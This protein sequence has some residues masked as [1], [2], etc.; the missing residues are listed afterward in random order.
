MGNLIGA[1][2]EFCIGQPART[3]LDSQV[4][5]L[6]GGVLLD[7]WRDGPFIFISSLDVYGDPQQIPV[8]E[9]HPLVQSAGDYAKSEITGYA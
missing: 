4:I 2:V 5:R 1:L 8:T 9:A 6:G 7:V 3:R